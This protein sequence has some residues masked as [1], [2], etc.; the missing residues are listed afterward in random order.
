LG[1]AREDWCPQRFKWELEH[2]KLLLPSSC[3]QRN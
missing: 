1:G 2:R 3:S